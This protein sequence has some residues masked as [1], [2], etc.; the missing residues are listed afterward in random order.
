MSKNWFTSKTVLLTVAG[1]TSMIV[2]IAVGEQLVPIEYQSTAL[3]FSALALR[4]VT[5][6]SVSLPSTA[7]VSSIFTA[8]LKI[9]HIRKQ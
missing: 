7:D 1:I 4:F 2:Q 6:E 3:L 9:L 8:V 5:H